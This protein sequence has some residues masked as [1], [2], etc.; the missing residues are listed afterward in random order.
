MF[1]TMVCH[2]VTPARPFSRVI[3]LSRGPSP[4]AGDQQT[5]I[6]ETFRSGLT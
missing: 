4:S 5:V 6:A 2:P 1:E 3:C